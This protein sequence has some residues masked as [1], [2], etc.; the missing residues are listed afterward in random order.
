MSYANPVPE[1]LD[2]V[3]LVREAGRGAATPAEMLLREARELVAELDNHPY[4]EQPSGVQKKLTR[5][6]QGHTRGK[7][8]GVLLALQAV[9]VGSDHFADDARLLETLL[10]AELRQQ[11]GGS[12]T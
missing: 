4:Y 12:R 3:P 9:L 2:F 10:W 5:F 1:G 8:D 7:L 11:Q 6:E